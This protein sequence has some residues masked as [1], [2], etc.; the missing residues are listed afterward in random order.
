MKDLLTKFLAVVIMVMGLYRIFSYKD[1]DTFT[2][3]YYVVWS[4]FLVSTIEVKKK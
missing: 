3:V 2:V 1:V 4:L